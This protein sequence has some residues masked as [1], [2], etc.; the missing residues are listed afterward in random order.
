VETTDWPEPINTGALL[1]EISKL[2][3]E[4]D[5]WH[6]TIRCQAEE[7]EELRVLCVRAAE[8][9]SKWSM[10]KPYLESGLIAE[11]RKAAK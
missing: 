7:I 1:L 3:Q 10:A 2:K 9:L 8:A 4:A 5:T 11:L 6:T